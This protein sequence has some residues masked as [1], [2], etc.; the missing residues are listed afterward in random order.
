MFAAGLATA[1]WLYSAHNQRVLSRTQQTLTVL[2]QMRNSKEFNDRVTLISTRKLLGMPPDAHSMEILRTPAAKIEDENDRQFRQSVIFVL[3]YYEF[4]AAGVVHNGLDPDLVAETIGAQLTSAETDF[5]DFVA[6]AEA[7]F[8]V[9]EN[10]RAMAAFIRAKDRARETPLFH[11][12][13]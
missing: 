5:G 4:I 11:R 13:M 1:G 6:F 3:N 8:S 12:P 10:L 2:L 9:Y 7:R